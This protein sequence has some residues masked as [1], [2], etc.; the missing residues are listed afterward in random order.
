MQ[1]RSADMLCNRLGVEIAQMVDLPAPFMY[2]K[3]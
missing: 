2:D 3:E 1:L